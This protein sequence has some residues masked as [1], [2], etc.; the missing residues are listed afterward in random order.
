MVGTLKDANKYRIYWQVNGCGTRPVLYT[1]LINWKQVKRE[2]DCE[3]IHLNDDI[4]PSN[5]NE[6]TGANL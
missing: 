1:S 5:T 4:C 3:M 6:Y 2:F